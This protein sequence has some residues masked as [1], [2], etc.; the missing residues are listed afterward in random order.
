[1]KQPKPQNNQPKQFTLK[2]TEPAVLID[3]LV[4]KL[5]GQSRS[6][7]KQLI[8]HKC[9][10]LGSKKPLAANYML[11]AGDVVAVRSQKEQHKELRHQQLR[12]VFEDEHILAVEKREG[13]LSVATNR[14]KERTVYN[15]LNEHVQ[16]FNKK[17][18]VFV[19]HRL[20]RETSGIMIFAKTPEAQE[21]LR[22]DWN[23]TILERQYIAIVEGRLPKKSGTIRTWLWEDKQ[24]YVH[25]SP[26]PIDNGQEAITHYK[27]LKENGSRAMVRLDLETG[28]TNQIRVHMTTQG[29]HVVGDTKYGPDPAPHCRMMLHAKTIRFRHPMTGKEMW[30]EMRLPADFEKALKQG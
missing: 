22:Q 28:R 21:R 12:I 6:S 20:D 9:V 1:M 25:S 27:V 23:E 17:Q 24:T 30:F 16:K 14:E 10:W 19:V 7:I 29:C 15:I 18:H 13:L 11:Q 4:A 5:G 3:F 26:T 8:G 2:V